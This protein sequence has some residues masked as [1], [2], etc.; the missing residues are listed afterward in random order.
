MIAKMELEVSDG[1]SLPILQKILN[2][3][4]NNNSNSPSTAVLMYIK[5]DN[6]EVVIDLGVGYRLYELEKS[7]IQDIKGIFIKNIE[8]TDK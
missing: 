1:K 3:S 2:I 6:Q 4:K 5:K 8:Y 7:R